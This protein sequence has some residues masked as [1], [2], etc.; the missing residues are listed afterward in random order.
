[1]TATPTAT[2]TPPPAQADLTVQKAGAPNPVTAGQPLTYTITV[3]NSGTVAATIPI[4]AVLL[5]DLL[6]ANLPGVQT[7]PPA[8]YQCQFTD[9]NQLDCAATVADTIPPGGTRVLTIQAL[10]PTTGPYP[11]T[12]TN[13]AT[14]DP[15]GVIAETNE[16]NNQASVVTTVVAATLPDLR[17][18]S[19]ND[20]PDPAIAGQRIRYTVNVSNIGVDATGVAVRITL[21]DDVTF[22]SAAGPSGFT[23]SYTPPSTVDCTGGAI[24]QYSGVGL[25]VQVDAPLGVMAEQ[26]LTISAVVD[27]DN[28]IVE[29]NETNNTVSGTTTVQP[30]FPADLSVTINDYPDPV[31][32]GAT[33]TYDIDVFNTGGTDV[34]GATLQIALPAGAIFISANTWSGLYS[35][36][37]AA[38]TYNAG[39]HSVTCTG[40]NIPLQ[41][42]APV[43][44]KVTAPAAAGTLSLTATVDPANTISESNDANNSATATTTVP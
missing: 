32:Q 7:T 28:T 18:D 8:G 21:P 30:A 1:M 17:A 4:G 25:L 43:T 39:D 34:T 44:I 13:T 36:E 10:G 37:F 38:C 19:I 11:Q 42:S 15:N 23:C 9:S 35:G 31:A 12:I 3:T 14:A 33:L 6:P 29:S 41:N 26:T 20:D 27:P 40:G 2:P 5:R 22:V 16:A 24:P